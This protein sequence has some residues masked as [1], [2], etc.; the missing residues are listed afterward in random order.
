MT[1]Q[2]L[3]V[4]LSFAHELLSCLKVKY[5]SLKAYLVVARLGG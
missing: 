4:A 5:P 3:E 1:L 2:E